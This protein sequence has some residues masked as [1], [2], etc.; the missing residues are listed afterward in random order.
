M[1]LNLLDWTKSP[2]SG[3]TE[4]ERHKLDQ[5]FNH[6]KPGRNTDEDANERLWM[7]HVW[8]AALIQ[9]FQTAPALTKPFANQIVSVVC[10]FVPAELGCAAGRR[11][12][13]F[14]ENKIR[15][16]EAQCCIQ[17]GQIPKSK[18][19]LNLKASCYI[20]KTKSGFVGEAAGSH[21]HHFKARSSPE[22]YC[23]HVRS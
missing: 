20:C 3:Q 18:A 7:R 6:Q 15:A 17:G 13:G 12:E 4:A 11:P 5:C 8:P 9:C 1:T 14:V 23:H 21:L 2:I 16:K 19:L 22:N 10:R